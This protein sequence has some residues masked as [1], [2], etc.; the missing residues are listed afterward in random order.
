MKKM[1]ILAVAMLTLLGL[2]LYADSKDEPTTQ[3]PI[4]ATTEDTTEGATSSEE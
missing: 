3:E 1:S 4:A 2:N